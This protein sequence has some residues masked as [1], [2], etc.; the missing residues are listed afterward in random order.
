LALTVKD[1]AKTLKISDSALLERMQNAGLSHSKNTDEI[2]AAD[3]QA[4]LRS[5][6]GAKTTSPKSVTSGTGVTVTSK[7]KISKETEGTKSYSDNIEAKRAAASEQLKEQQ[8]KR[9]D[10]LKEAARL[11]QEEIKKRE[12]FKKAEP[13]R[14]AKKV[15]VKD[16]LSSAVNAYKRREGS[17]SEDAEHKFEAPTEFIKKI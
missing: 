8:K 12:K 14:P 9:E 16:Q 10:Q 15:N 7:G 5:L 11:K 2:T 1:F 4:L 3:K 17:F 6:K 13:E